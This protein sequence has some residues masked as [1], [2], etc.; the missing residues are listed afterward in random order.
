MIIISYRRSFFFSL[1]TGPFLHPLHNCTFHV[2]TPCDV[3]STL[4]LHVQPSL[5]RDYLALT[6]FRLFPLLYGKI[7]KILNSKKSII[8]SCIFFS[9]L[10]AASISP[11][12]TDIYTF[13]LGSVPDGR[14]TAEQ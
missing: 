10:A 11:A 1:L 13:I 8:L 6:F 7:Q 2:I 12:L 5:E 9:I 3:Y 4:I 14:I